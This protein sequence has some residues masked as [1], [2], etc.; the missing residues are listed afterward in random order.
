MGA[1]TA[2]AIVLRALD[3]ARVDGIERDVPDVSAAF[4]KSPR[5]AS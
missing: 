4:L 3:H 1:V 5:A 2:P